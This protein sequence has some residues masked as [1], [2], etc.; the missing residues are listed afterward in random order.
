MRR[1]PTTKH[2]RPLVGSTPQ[3]AAYSFRPWRLLTISN[4]R[5]VVAA[6]AAGDEAT[7]G[8]A[9]VG[10]ATASAAPD[11]NVRRVS[12]VC[13]CVVATRAGRDGGS[14]DG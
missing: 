1:W 12:M 11:K 7:N 10:V 4:G 5:V 3:I 13:S 2:Q 9:R 14:I 8:A 6:S